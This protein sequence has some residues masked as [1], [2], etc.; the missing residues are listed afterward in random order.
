MFNGFPPTGT[1][2]VYA[3]STPS[4]KIGFKKDCIYQKRKDIPVGWPDS[5]PFPN[6]QGIGRDESLVFFKVRSTMNLYRH[7]AKEFNNFVLL[8]CGGMNRRL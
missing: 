8:M 6:L 7:L 1:S 5:Y 4:R 2:L 3:L